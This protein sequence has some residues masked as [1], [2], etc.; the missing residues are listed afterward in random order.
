[1]I[2]WKGKQVEVEWGTEYVTPKYATLTCGLFQAE[3]HQISTDSR[4]AVHL[5]FNCL[6]EFK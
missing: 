1:M 6:K 4:R 3:D 5:S 2:Y